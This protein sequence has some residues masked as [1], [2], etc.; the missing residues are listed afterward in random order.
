MSTIHPDQNWPTV[1]HLQRG[2]AL[3]S[4]IFLLVVLGL[5]AGFATYFVSVQSSSLVLDLRGA[6][7]LQAANAGL[8][9]GAWQVLR[10]GGT[11]AA[12]TTLGTLGGTLAPF[13]VVVNC[14]SNIHADDGMGNALTDYALTSTASIGTLGS[15]YVSRR[16]SSVLAQ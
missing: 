12:S 11:C 5:L 2:F 4:A 3:V 10:N 13:T 14:T 8:E 6:Q 16:V 15:D 1:P 9:Y 7:A